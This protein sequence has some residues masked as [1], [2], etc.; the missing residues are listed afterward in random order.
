MRSVKRGN[1]NTKSLAYKPV[2]RPILEYGAACWDPYREC[3]VSVLDRVQYKAAKFAHNSG[4]SD[5]ESWAQRRK[6]ARLCALYAAY[7]G[8]R[9]WKAIADRLQA[10]SY[11]T[12]WHTQ[13]SLRRPGSLGPLTLRLLMSHIYIIYIYIYMGRLFLMFLDHT[14]RRSKVGRT[15]LDE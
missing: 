2:G 7:T 13:T 10:P 8:E 1:K 14:Q 4:G 15:P 5:W 11:L 6:I 3:Q 9:A 12:H